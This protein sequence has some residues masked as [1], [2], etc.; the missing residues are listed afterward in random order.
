[1]GFMV[2]NLSLKQCIR[3]VEEVDDEEIIIIWVC[4]ILDRIWDMIELL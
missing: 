2:S 4:M 1:M 3:I